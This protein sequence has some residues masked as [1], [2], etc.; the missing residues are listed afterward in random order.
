MSAQTVPTL[1]P[2]IGSKQ[3]KTLG[4]VAQYLA[5]DVQMVADTGS[6]WLAAEFR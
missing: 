4:I 5:R 2:T 6:P 3:L 1:T